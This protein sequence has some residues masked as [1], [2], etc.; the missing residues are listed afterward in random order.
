MAYKSLR[1]EI[2]NSITHGIGAVLSVAGL[3]ALLVY[4]A[5]EGGAARVTTYAVFGTTMFLVYLASTLY[6]SFQGPRIKR[7][8]RFCD[9]SAIYLLIAGTYTPFLLLNLS[10]AWGWT[11]FVIMWSL[12]LLGVTFEVLRLRGSNPQTVFLYLLMG[13]AA[14][15]AFKPIFSNIH[16]EGI[17]WIVA[18]GLAYTLGVAFYLWE[19]LPYNHAVWH[20]FVLKGSACHFIAVMFYAIPAHMS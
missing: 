1:E 17:G 4:A 16:I 5:G 19:R 8:F 9:R 12:A 7:F 3:V 13:W 2:A 18:G 20:V 6:H 11:L 15:F 14:V 10:G